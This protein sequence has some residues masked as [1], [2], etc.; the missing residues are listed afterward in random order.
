[1]ICQTNVNSKAVD[2]QQDEWNYNKENYSTPYLLRYPVRR[3]VGGNEDQGR[4]NARLRIPE[5]L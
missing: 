5:Q 4:E 3:E 1:M 2:S